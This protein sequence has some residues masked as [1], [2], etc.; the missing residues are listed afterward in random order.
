[1]SSVILSSHRPITWWHVEVGD[2]SLLRS[3]IKADCFLSFLIIFCF[4]FK[5]DIETKKEHNFWISKNSMQ[6]T[7]RKSRAEVL[8]S[9]SH[10][11]SYIRLQWGQRWAS[12][13]QVTWSWANR[14]NFYCS[15]VLTEVSWSIL[16]CLHTPSV[17]MFTSN[18]YKHQTNE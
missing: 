18:C 4:K 15:S 1:M 8:P 3:P 12:Q 17:Q 2:V 9:P 13:W 14:V 10:S 7:L 16:Q 5:L 11:S 6:L